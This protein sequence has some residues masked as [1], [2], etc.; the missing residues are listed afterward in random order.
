MD[1]S[2][3]VPGKTFLVA[4]VT[5]AVADAANLWLSFDGMING[6]EQN[7]LKLACSAAY[8]R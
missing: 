4:D 2:K 6:S 7:E 8:N 1:A 5:L 3:S